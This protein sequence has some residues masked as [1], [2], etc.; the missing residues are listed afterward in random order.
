MGLMEGMLTPC[1]LTSLGPASSGASP[2][3]LRLGCGPHHTYFF[4][5]PEE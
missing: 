4:P 5:R 1:W 3:P 2:G